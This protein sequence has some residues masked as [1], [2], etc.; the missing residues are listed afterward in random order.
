MSEERRPGTLPAGIEN[1]VRPG[2]P[3]PNC[4][5]PARSNDETNGLWYMAYLPIGA[6]SNAVARGKARH[7]K[8][9]P[10]VDEQLDVFRQ[11]QAAEQAKAEAE[12]AKAAEKAA[13]GK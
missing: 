7:I 3:L 10:P 13:K 11:K 12:A 6:L 4:W 5:K 1:A 2:G 8:D 9:A